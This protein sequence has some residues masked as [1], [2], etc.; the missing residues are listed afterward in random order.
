LGAV[1]LKVSVYKDYENGRL[2]LGVKV[3]AEKATLADLLEAWEPLA[4]DDSVFKQYALD[5]YSP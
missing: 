5:H 4:D 2:G 3:V 1:V